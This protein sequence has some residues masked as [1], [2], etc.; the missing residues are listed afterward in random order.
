M[1]QEFYYVFDDDKELIGLVK[2]TSPQKAIRMLNGRYAID[3]LGE[4]SLKFY[5][6]LTSGVLKY[7]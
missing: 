4:W 5:F 6:K 7:E 3:H 2:A 1:K